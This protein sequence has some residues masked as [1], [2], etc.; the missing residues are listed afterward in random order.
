MRSVTFLCLTMLATGG[1][2]CIGRLVRPGSL[3][4]RVVALDTLL[5]VVVAAVTVDAA[6]QRSDAFVDVVLVVALVAFIGTSTV[7]R[8]MQRR[9]PR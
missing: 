8:F 2:L 7:A 3:A 5:A 1:L 9:G 6:G 4:D